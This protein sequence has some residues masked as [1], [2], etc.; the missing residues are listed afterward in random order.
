MIVVKH[1]R[2]GLAT[3]LDGEE[4]EEG[5]KAG[6]EEESHGNA[7]PSPARRARQSQSADLKATPRHAWQA[8]ER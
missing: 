1:A 6:E 4:D 3:P 5:G 8:R 7:E 2:P